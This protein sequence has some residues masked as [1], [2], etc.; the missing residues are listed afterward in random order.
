MTGFI[1]K[2]SEPYNKENGN[3]YLDMVAYAVSQ[4]NG[5]MLFE[6]L[7]GDQHLQAVFRPT[8]VAI[9]KALSSC[10]A[11]Q[12][13]LTIIPPPISINLSLVGCKT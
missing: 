10:N 3:D 8:M 6:E 2:N 11:F 1:E 5:S 12:M 13:N 7:C 4:A 9:L